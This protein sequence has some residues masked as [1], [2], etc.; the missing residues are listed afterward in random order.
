[1]SIKHIINNKRGIGVADKVFIIGA[2]IAMAAGV[3][4]ELG[5]DL[6]KFVKGIPIIKSINIK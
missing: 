6:D 1:M 4:E 5:K 2:A 3:M